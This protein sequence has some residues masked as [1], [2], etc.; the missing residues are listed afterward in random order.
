VPNA[1]IE[2][3]HA[4]EGVNFAVVGDVAQQLAPH[5]KPQGRS[6]QGNDPLIC[7]KSRGNEKEHIAAHRDRTALRGGEA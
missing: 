1:K 4:R 3:S 2:L 5:Q 7:R 6:T